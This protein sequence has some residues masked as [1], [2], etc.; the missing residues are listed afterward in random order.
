[1]VISSSQI[2][3]TLLWHKSY[4]QIAVTDAQIRQTDAVLYLLDTYKQV[5]ITDA[6]LHLKDVCIIVLDTYIQAVITNRQQNM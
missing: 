3:K 5:V 4:T 6:L 2:I 1:M